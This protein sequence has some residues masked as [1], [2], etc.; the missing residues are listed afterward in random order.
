MTDCDDDRIRRQLPTFDDGPAVQTPGPDDAVLLTA[1]TDDPDLTVR[2]ELSVH[3]ALCKGLSSYI[4]SLSAA[5]EGRRIALSRVVEDWAD[6][7]DGAIASP[8]AVVG[9]TEVGKYSELSLGM[10][11]PEVIAGAGDGRVI[12]LT[13]SA[14]YELEEL[15]VQVMCEDKIQRSGV[16]LMLEDGFAPVDWMAGFRLRLPRYHNAVGQYLLIAAQLPDATDSAS[17]GLWPL[18]MR[19]TATCSVYQVR[20]LP[21]ARPIVKGT[22]TRR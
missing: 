1:S 7:D 8:S 10:T 5:I 22:I 12:A 20:V 6:H 19:L 11:K 17:Q 9:S 15:T 4:L 3:D 18:V 14:F 21:L 16:R 2:H 13:S